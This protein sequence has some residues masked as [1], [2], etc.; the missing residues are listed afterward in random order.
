ME[1]IKNPQKLQNDD[2]LGEMMDWFRI[3]RNGDGLK[4]KERKY[5]QDLC[6]EIKRRNLLDYRNLFR[7]LSD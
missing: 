7:D 6:K 4:G 3:G 1:T 5:F 2:L